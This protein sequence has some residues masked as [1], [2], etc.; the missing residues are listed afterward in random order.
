MKS[1]YKQ[2][3]SQAGELE[4]EKKLRQSYEELL[5][6]LDA[7]LNGGQHSQ[8]MSQLQQ[9][10]KNELGVPEISGAVQMYLKQADSSVPLNDQGVEG[11][12]EYIHSVY[13]AGYQAGVQAVQQAQKGRL[14]GAAKADSASGPQQK[15][16]RAQIAG[17]NP[18]TFAKYEKEIFS[19]LANGGLA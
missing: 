9:K 14:S 3:N 8:Y 12:I 6:A 13:A 7:E 4:R 1:T 18:D 17:M 16:T 11:A 5:K 2:E 19:Q 10:Y 15:F